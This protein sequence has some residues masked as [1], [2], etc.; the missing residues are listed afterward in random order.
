M[1]LNLKISYTSAAFS[2]KNAEYLHP[3]SSPAQLVSEPFRG[4]SFSISELRIPPLL[5]QGSED[6]IRKALPK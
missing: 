6:Q 3:S 1:H 5:P 2:F 4:S